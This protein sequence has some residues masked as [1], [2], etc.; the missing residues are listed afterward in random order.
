[1]KD[2]WKTSVGNHATNRTQHS[3]DANPETQS[4]SH[5]QGKQP[6]LRSKNPIQVN[7]FGEQTQ[8]FSFDSCACSCRMSDP[9]CSTCLRFFEI[10][11]CNFDL[12]MKKR[13][14]DDWSTG[15]G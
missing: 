12:W 5:D 10:S 3:E 15:A 4:K 7:L 9:S 14:S 2:Q 1:M 13:A 6:F 8:E 11:G